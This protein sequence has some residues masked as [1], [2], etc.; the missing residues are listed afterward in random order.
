MALDGSRAPI[1]DCIQNIFL[2][3][4]IGFFGWLSTRRFNFRI[5]NWLIVLFY[6][7][8]LSFSVEFFQLF[9]TDRTTSVTDVITNTTGTFLGMSLAFYIRNSW[10][11]I[12]DQEVI[13]QIVHYPL[14]TPLIFLTCIISA[15]LLLPLILPSITVC[16]N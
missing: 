15:Y 7:A 3:M 10:K 9:T 5:N 12:S 16:S 1:S 13:T 4:P 8:F 14:F 11:K 2:F 6:G